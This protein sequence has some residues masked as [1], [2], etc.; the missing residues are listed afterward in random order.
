MLK[1]AEA[2]ER[3]KPPDGLENF[4]RRLN[5]FEA[6]WKF[7][8]RADWM[9][10][11]LE[12]S[13]PTLDRRLRLFSCRCVRRWWHFLHDTRS[14]RA[15]AAAEGFAEG[16]V[17]K[18][19]LEYMR[20]GAQKAVDD[21]N[22]STKPMH[23]RAARMALNTLDHNLLTAARENSSLAAA[24]EHSIKDTQSYEKELLILGEQA[25]WLREILGNPFR[26]SLP[27]AAAATAPSVEPHRG[28]QM[29]P[30]HPGAHRDTSRPATVF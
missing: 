15:V 8:E 13:S 19:A 20:A 9:L 26:D 7:C 4:A 28:A 18:T 3:F 27:S 25:Q 11:M 16:R 6:A 29:R 22:A 12:H 23:A 2:L 1:L 5:S 30:F 24:A 17:S 14:Q 21:A 10:W